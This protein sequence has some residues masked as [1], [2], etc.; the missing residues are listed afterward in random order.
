[1]QAV[2]SRILIADDDPD[3]REALVEIL[4][5]EG[6]ETVA[7]ASAEA[8]L[9]ALDTQVFQAVL[10]DI[11]GAPGEERL[12]QVDA[13]ARRAQPIPVGVISGWHVADGELRQHG[14]RFAMQKPFDISELLV[15]VAQMRGEPLDPRSDPAAALAMRYFE[16]LEKKDWD[17]LV[18]LCAEDVRFEGPRSPEVELLGR[19]ALRSHAVEMFT[20]FRD[21]RFSDFICY[22][23][24][25]GIAVRYLGS[26]TRNGERVQLAG[27]ALLRIDGGIIARIG[28]VLNRSL[29]GLLAPD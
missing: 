29:L 6:Y 11:F 9:E 13:I 2:R 5:G 23:T 10:T 15:A 3:I 16:A 19:D 18:A 1:M 7:V 25:G 12:A 14:L 8:A 26:W 17:G 22:A 27:T 21:A 20:L 4:S 28:V 24:P